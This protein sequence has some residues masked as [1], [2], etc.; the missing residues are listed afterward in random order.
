MRSAGLGDR[1]RCRV[2]S[3]DREILTA[4]SVDVRFQSF[5]QLQP[6][7]TV[8]N[9]SN[10]CGTARVVRDGRRG[11]S[12]RAQVGTVFLGSTR[13]VRVCVSVCVCPDV[14]TKKSRT[15]PLRA[16]H[17]SS[18][19]SQPST[20]F[21]TCGSTSPSPPENVR[22]QHYHRGVHD[23]SVAVASFCLTCRVSS[24]LDAH[25]RSR[26]VDESARVL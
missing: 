11:K 22:T 15:Y 23:S 18:R 12:P 26:R 5:R 25:G 2:T 19:P 4:V 9:A 14:E 10:G 8:V 20:S 17:F 3:L 21:E 24:S 7:R 1:L 6:K 13:C 16:I